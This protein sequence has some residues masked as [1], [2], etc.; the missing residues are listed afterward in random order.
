[1]PAN[2]TPAA[3]PPDSAL[4]DLLA[5]SNVRAWLH[6][7]LAWLQTH[8]LVP[9]VGIQLGLIIA[10]LV[11]GALFGP[12][13]RAFILAQAELRAQIGVIRRAAQAF[14]ILA[15]PIA[16]Y[17]SW[18][19]F[20]LALGSAGQPTDWIDA[21]ISLL[22]AWI[23]IRM[24]TLVIRSPFWSRVAFYVIWPIAVLDAF[25]ML[26]GVIAQL[27]AWAIPLGED[28]SGHAVAISLFDI[29][30]TLIYFA[31]LFWGA[32]VLTRF[33]ENRIEKVDEL[34]PALRA[35]IVKLLRVLFPIA[36]LLIALQI[37][38]F[39]LATLAIFSGAVGLGIGLGLQ[40]VVANFVAGFTLIADRSIKPFDVIQIGNTFG[41]VTEMQA[42]YVALR[43]RDG[44]EHLIPN[45]NFMSQGV[46]NWSRSDRTIRLH[47][48]FSVSYATKDLRAVQALAIEAAKA[49]SRV[50]DMPSPVC[51]VAGFGD[52]GVEFDL[53]FWIADPASGLGNVRSDVFLNVWDKLRENGIEIPFPQRDL[54]IKSW[55]V[56][57]ADVPVL[58]SDPAPAKR[59]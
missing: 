50:V 8:V 1:V 5:P 26:D 54:H 17:L 42:R 59:T 10:A 35:L 28:D 13:I 3:S 57:G 7:T 22:S 20:K 41:W 16:L 36:A 15:T 48:P 14:A 46:I 49:V 51:N 45:D 27:R 44:T 33:I 58:A 9:Q 34:T 23:V 12:R 56:S 38:G 39:N 29:L 32:N 21:A 53:R 24:I 40:G 37:V 47:A 30:R 25:N 11:P 2:P 43:T 4:G 55:E 18:T 19:V 52:S 6:E 31:V